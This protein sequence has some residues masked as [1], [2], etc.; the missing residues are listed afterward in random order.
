[1]ARSSYVYVVQNKHDQLLATFT[2]KRECLVWLW[3]EIKEKG[4]RHIAEWKVTRA[5]DGRG[6]EHRDE[7]SMPADQYLELHSEGIAL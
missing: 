1:M 2:V 4:W 7:L 3:S 6:F 5:P